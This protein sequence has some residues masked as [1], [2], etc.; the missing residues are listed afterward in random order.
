MELNDITEIFRKKEGKP[1]KI[2]SQEAI[3]ILGYLVGEDVGKIDARYKLYP[4][5][6]YHVSSCIE[7]HF[8]ELSSVIKNHIYDGTGNVQ[9]DGEKC[10]IN[11]EGPPEKV[12]FGICTCREKMEITIDKI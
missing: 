8:E 3:D 9:Y 11:L 2:N 6:K 10:I 1:T 5:L 7:E 4:D 12:F